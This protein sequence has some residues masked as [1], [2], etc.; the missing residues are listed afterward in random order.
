MGERD[1]TWFGFGTA[2]DDGGGRSGVVRGTERAG[3]DDGVGFTGDGVDFGDSD[4]FF[5]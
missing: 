3:G 1:F 2:A 5:R 4:L